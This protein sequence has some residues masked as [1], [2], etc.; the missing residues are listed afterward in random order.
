MKK[1]VVRLLS[2]IDNNYAPDPIYVS[3]SMDDILKKI[4]ENVG[5]IALLKKFRDSSKAS[6][7]VDLEY[8]PEV[9]S[10]TEYEEEE[11]YELTGFCVS[12]KVSYK[13]AEENDNYLSEWKIRFC[14]LYFI[15][16]CEVNEEMIFSST[17]IGYGDVDL[18][19]EK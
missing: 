6:F 18:D 2:Q 7:V 14:P 17:I 5:D 11:M 12:D 9:L 3:F 1:L 10:L 19:V 15:I 13:V 16:L 4:K 8:E